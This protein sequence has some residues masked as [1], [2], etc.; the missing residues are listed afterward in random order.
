MSEITERYLTERETSYSMS[1][2]DKNIV[3]LAKKVTD[4]I[5]KLVTSLER[6]DDPRSKEVDRLGMKIVTIMRKKR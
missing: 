5:D 2:F 6:F 1:L 3:I 4:A